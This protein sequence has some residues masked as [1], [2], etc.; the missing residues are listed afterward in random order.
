MGIHLLIYSALS[1]GK[2]QHIPSFVLSQSI[3]VAR[4][5]MLS[6]PLRMISRRGPS[7]ASR[8]F[9]TSPAVS[10]AEVKSLGV[11]GAGQ[12][13]CLQLKRLFYAF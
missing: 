13:V 9:S 2:L 5:E 1:F 11:I 12:M 7:M 6:Q 4:A 8:A 10:A 3:L